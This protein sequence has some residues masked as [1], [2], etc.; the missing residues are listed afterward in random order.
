M[1]KDIKI[2]PVS[3]EHIDSYH[4]CVDSVAKERLYLAGTEAPPLEDAQSFIRESI[5]KDL[6]HFVD[7]I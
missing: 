5:E 2:L 1:R 7:M 4:S 6:P 3:E